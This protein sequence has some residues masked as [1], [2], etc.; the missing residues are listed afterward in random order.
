MKLT[1]GSYINNL[2]HEEFP[3]CFRCHDDGHETKDG[4]VISQDCSLCHAVLSWEEDSPS[5]L[6]ELGIE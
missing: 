2:G 4:E 6:A 1:W 5:I 3:G